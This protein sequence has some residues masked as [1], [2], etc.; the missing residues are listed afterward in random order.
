VRRTDDAPARVRI[1]CVVPIADAASGRADTEWVRFAGGFRGH[2]AC[3]EDLAVGIYVRGKVLREY[4]S[5]DLARTPDNV[6]ESVSHY[7]WCRR[8]IG[9][10]WLTAP[11]AKALKFGF[12]VETLDKRVLCFDAAT[13]ELL[14]GWA[15]ERSIGGG[16]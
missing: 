15:P 13:G 7:A 12:A 16:D 3:A 2:R 1:T 8:P 6:S 10:R 4:S 9:F 14:D 11:G 5:L